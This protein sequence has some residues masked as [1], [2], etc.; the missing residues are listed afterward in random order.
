M[1]TEIKAC[2][3]QDTEFKWEGEKLKDAWRLPEKTQIL[4]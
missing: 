4:E 1:K 3:T 2:S